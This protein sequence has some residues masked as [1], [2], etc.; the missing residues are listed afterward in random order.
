MI[1]IALLLLFMK[2]QVLDTFRYM[3]VEMKAL[4][5]IM[6]PFIA[7]CNNS[8]LSLL[9]VIFYLL[10][11]SDFMKNDGLM[12]NIIYYAGRKNWIMGQFLF[13]VCSAGTYLLFLLLFNSIISIQNGYFGNTWSYVVQD[14]A[15]TFPEMADSFG[16]QLIKG[17]LFRQLSPFR[18]ITHSFLFHWMYLI[19]IGEIIILCYVYHLKKYGLTVAAFIIGAGTATTLV[20]EQIMWFFPA[21]HVNLAGHFNDYYRKMIYPIKYSYIVG[22]ISIVILALIL[23][24]RAD[25]ITFEDTIENVN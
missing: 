3:S 14:Y 15:S 9:V 12:Q 11:L 22:F 1:M 19:V 24:L 21:A 10:L 16:A 18:A 7:I 2:N 17:N 5:N 4:C 25:G 13:V 20:S 8:A 23:W 6:E